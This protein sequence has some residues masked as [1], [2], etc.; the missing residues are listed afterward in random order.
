MGT[1]GEGETGR[2]A[3]LTVTGGNYRYTAD[4]S[5]LP[6]STTEKGLSPPAMA[7]EPYGVPCILSQK[8]LNFDPAPYSMRA[9]HV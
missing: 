8:V 3:T 9:P 5:L 7:K 2:K 4:G 1:V 6:V